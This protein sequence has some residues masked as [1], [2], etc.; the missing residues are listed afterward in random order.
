[1]YL[2]SSSDVKNRNLEFQCL[3][4]FLIKIVPPYNMDALLRELHK[5]ITERFLD[6]LLSGSYKLNSNV[7][8]LF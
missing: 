3:L 5:I 2:P 8:M 7:N 6:S 4:Q 1:M